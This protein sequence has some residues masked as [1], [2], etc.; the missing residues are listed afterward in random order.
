MSLNL[1]INKIIFLFF[2][3]LT[4]NPIF[5]VKKNDKL[6]DQ[7]V[8]YVN[9]FVDREKEAN[10]ILQNLQSYKIASVIGVTNIGKTEIVRKYAHFNKSSYNLIW[11][12]D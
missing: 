1:K 11:F 6:T 5:A 7:I 4:A 12:F 9:F 10:A 2:I 3:I 8:N